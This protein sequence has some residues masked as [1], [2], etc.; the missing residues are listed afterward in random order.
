MK[1]LLLLFGFLLFAACDSDSTGLGATGDVLFEIEYVNFAWFPTW[2][3]YYIDSD[4]SV[5]SY[6][7][8]DKRDSYPPTKSSYSSQELTE[9]FSAKRAH[10]RTLSSSEIL[11]K[12]ALILPAAF[13]PLSVVQARCADAGVLTYRAYTY[14]FVRRRYTPVLL[15]EQGDRAQENRSG[16]ARQLFSWLDSLQLIQRFQGCQP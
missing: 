8:S 5:W 12:Q 4:G 6:D 3:G 2:Q 9:K 14:D 1:R 16:Q 13:G 11:E 10:V 15:Y 7:R